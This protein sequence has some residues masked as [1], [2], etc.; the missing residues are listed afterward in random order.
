MNTCE[1]KEFLQ[2]V[3]TINTSIKRLADEYNPI[4]EMTIYIKDNIETVN[5]NR[6]IN[7]IKAISM[8][9]YNS[10]S[11]IKQDI[12]ELEESATGELHKDVHINALYKR[13]SIRIAGFTAARTEFYTVLDKEYA[14][15]GISP[16]ST[17]NMHTNTF[18]HGLLE[19]STNEVL[20]DH[21]HSPESTEITVGEERHKVER[22]QPELTETTL[23]IKNMVTDLSD[24]E[25]LAI[26]LNMIIELSGDKIDRVSYTT[27]ELKTLS[28]TSNKELTQ[29]IRKKKRRTKLKR[30]LMLILL[31]LLIILGTFLGTK[32]FNF[33]TAAKKA[34]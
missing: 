6:M 21:M 28:Q 22:Q 24:L 20:H 5:V 9:F 4:I 23:F 3:S 16:M 32:I 30:F 29:G 19:G 15:K 31:V 8:A 14:M 11:T 12:K 7:D 17:P 18:S 10:S 27:V 13:L 33:I 26:E 1:F 25:A 34:F 2:R